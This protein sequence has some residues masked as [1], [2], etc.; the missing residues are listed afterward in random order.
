MRKILTL[1]GLTISLLTAVALTLSATSFATPPQDAECPAGTELG[2]TFEADEIFVGST[3]DGVTITDVQFDEDGEVDSFS[4]ESERP[5]GAVLVKAGRDEVAVIFDPPVTSGTVTTPTGH[6]ISHVHFCFAEE[7]PPTSPP[8][9]PTTTP[10]PPPPP[11]PPPATT[12]VP[13][14]VGGVETG[15]GSPDATIPTVIGLFLLAASLILW[16]LRSA[17]SRGGA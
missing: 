14:P 6:A 10:P 1:A 12:T 4:F 11:P 3:K 5:V 13:P 15:G 7:V 2:P 17:S 16:R 9:P 8:P